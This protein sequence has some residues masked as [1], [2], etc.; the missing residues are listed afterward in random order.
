M[1]ESM[2]NKKNPL[3]EKINLK[4]NVKSLNIIKHIFSNLP[5]NKKLNLIINNKQFQKK[6]KIDLEYY[7]KRSNKYK[8]QEKNGKGK[9]YTLYS[10]KLIFKGEYK[11][12]KK[13][14]KGKEFY[15]NGKI[16]FEG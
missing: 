12:K 15:E 13:N 16:K 3:I 5:E 9:E 11:N 2:N 6:L 7:K 10:N 1:K 4:N 8:I 14:G